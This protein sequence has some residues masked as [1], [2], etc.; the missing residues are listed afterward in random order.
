MLIFSC[1][2][3]GHSR[4]SAGLIGIVFMGSR[5]RAGEDGVDPRGLVKN[6]GEGNGAMTAIAEGI[7]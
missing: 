3:Y 1:Q 7:N 5:R 6:G 2:P 4:Q